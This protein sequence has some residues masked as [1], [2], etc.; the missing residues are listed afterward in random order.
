MKVK[1]A[2]FCLILCNSRDY[3]VHGILQSRI[4]EWVAF[5]FSRGL[6]NPGIEPW[7]PTLQADALPSEPPGK[8]LSYTQTCIL[9]LYSFPL[10]LIPRDWI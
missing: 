5:P 9:L 7:S 4:L 2:K 1:A 6:P 3:T 8:P 10:W